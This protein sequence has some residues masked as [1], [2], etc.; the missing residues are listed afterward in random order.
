MQ[1]CHLIEHF[2]GLIDNNHIF[3]AHAIRL[4]YFVILVF[5]RFFWVFLGSYE[6]NGLNT[7]ER[8]T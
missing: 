1:G 6:Q 2:I 3:V 4:Q 5:F 7:S 8:R